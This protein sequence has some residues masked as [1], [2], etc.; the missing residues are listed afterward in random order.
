MLRVDRQDRRAR[1]SSRG[2]DEF[3]GH[4]QRLLVGQRHGLAR[5]QCGERRT[6][7]GIADHRREHHVDRRHLHHVGDGI[8]AGPHFHRQ[9]GKRLLERR[10]MLFVG[11]HDHLGP[12]LA[13]LLGEQ[14]DVLSCHE[15]VDLEAIRVVPDDIERLCADRSGGAQQ[16]NLSLMHVC[17]NAMYSSGLT[18][19]PRYH[20]SK[21]RC[22]PVES[23]PVLPTS[24]MASPATT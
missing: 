18:D 5:L 8:R 2:R 6:K 15:G 1:T 11:N 12:E 24:A 19:V 20:S 7:P 17:Q 23:L 9:V 22:G 3:A 4:D 10:V 16:G 14:G 13:C 21:C